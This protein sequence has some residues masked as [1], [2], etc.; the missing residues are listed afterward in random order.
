[1]SLTKINIRND[2]QMSDIRGVLMVIKYVVIG[3]FSSYKNLRSSF[4][5]E[6]ELCSPLVPS[7]QS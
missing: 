5:A 2:P 4:P 1:M 6:Y 7:P 3:Y